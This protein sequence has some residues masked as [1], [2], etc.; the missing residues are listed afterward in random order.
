MTDTRPLPSAQKYAVGVFDTVAD[1]KASTWL[2][3]G[4]AAETRGYA[5]VADG[6]GGAY[7]IITAA[8]YALTPDG[9]ADHAITS[10]VNG[11]LVAALLPV[12]HYTPRQTSAKGDGV[13]DDRAAVQAFIDWKIRNAP[14]AAALGVFFDGMVAIDG[15]TDVFAV[16]DEVTV[17]V[18][19]NLVVTRLHL[20]ATGTTWNSSKFMLRNSA[21]WSSFEDVTLDCNKKANGMIDNGGRNRIVRPRVVRMSPNWTSDGIYIPGVGAGDTRII[22]PWVSQWT[23]DDAEFIDASKYTANGIRIEDSD[24]KIHDGNINWCGKAFVGKNGIHN[25]YNVHISNGREGQ[26]T[27]YTALATNTVLVDWGFGATNGELNLVGCYLDNGICNFYRDRVNLDVYALNDPLDSIITDGMFR[28]WGVFNGADLRAQGKIT[29]L[30][31][32]ATAVDMIRLLPNGATDFSAASYSLVAQLNTDFKAADPDNVVIELSRLKLEMVTH[33]TSQSTRIYEAAGFGI[34]G[35]G[36][37]I[38]AVSAEPAIMP[39]G[40]ISRSDGT[41]STNGFGAAGAGFYQKIAGYWQFL[42]GVSGG[43]AYTYVG[44]GSPEG[45]VAAPVGSEY[46]RLDGGAMT[47]LYAKESGGTGNTGWVGK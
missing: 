19:K 43:G 40:S 28:F 44:Y 7:S 38:T 25:L 16:T 15:G 5:A 34:N 30:Q 22:E 21:S 32:D 12:Q 36:L 14:T 37:T 42:G 31:W 27:L 29:P 20:L 2:F 3:A 6:G 4:M 47:T 8:A 26:A 46:R 11:S 41:P 45:V 39:N 17:P 9:I 33:S 1:M 10:T 18:R 23:T 13:A 35:P 24:C